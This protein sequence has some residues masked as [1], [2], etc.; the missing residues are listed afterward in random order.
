MYSFWFPHRKF[1][2]AFLKVAQTDEQLPE[3]I[4]ADSRTPAGASFPETKMQRRALVHPLRRTRRVTVPNFGPPSPSPPANS[5]NQLLS[6]ATP[7]KIF[8]SPFLAPRNMQAFSYRYAERDKIKTLVDWA[9]VKTNAGWK[10]QQA[11]NSKCR[12]C[13]K[14]GG[15]LV[16]GATAFPSSA[17][18]VSIVSL[19]SSIFLLQ[20][21]L[22]HGSLRL[23]TAEVD[24]AILLAKRTS[25]MRHAEYAL[26]AQ[27]A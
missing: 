8:C 24:T 23:Y 26:R 14:V 19:S 3:A 6:N 22:K 12:A 20:H 27:C 25:L 2:L 18:V 13:R 17:R 21:V 11:K 4:V 15:E 9:Q 1:I 16:V 5:W 7:R 10:S